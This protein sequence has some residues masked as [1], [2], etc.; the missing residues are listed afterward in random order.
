MKPE[1]VGLFFAM[2]EEERSGSGGGSV[3]ESRTRDSI[4]LGSSVLSATAFLEARRCD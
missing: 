1:S 2:M 4:G 3:G